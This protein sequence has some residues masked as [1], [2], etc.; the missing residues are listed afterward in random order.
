MLERRQRYA[1]LGSRLCTI[2]LE[3]GERVLTMATLQ[4]MFD[5][6][7]RWLGM[8]VVLLALLGVFLVY[9]EFT[10]PS[11]G[12][13]ENVVERYIEAKDD[14][15]PDALV[16][17]A[18]LNDDSRDIGFNLRDEIP[19][20]DLNGFTELSVRNSMLDD[21]SGYL[22]GTLD[23]ADDAKTRFFEAV[24]KMDE[25]VWKIVRI[26]VWSE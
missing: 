26:D 12:D 14:G 11:V 10:D 16:D 15:D 17:Y 22:Y 25:G 13:L 4:R 18:Y 19:L 9:R 5:T 1:K 7:L 6:A 21:D 24:L 8:A 2:G 20:E 3:P 23:F